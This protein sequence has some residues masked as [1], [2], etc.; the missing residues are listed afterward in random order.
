MPTPW[1]RTSAGPSPATLYAVPSNTPFIGAWLVTV[2]CFT[3]PKLLQI[4]IA[5]ANTM[6]RPT[7]NRCTQRNH[8][9]IGA[10]GID[11]RELDGEVMRAH[12]FI[13]LVHEWN[14]DRT[15][16]TTTQIRKTQ[17]ALRTHR[18]AELVAEAQRMNQRRRMFD[19]A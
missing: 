3:G 19:L 18:F 6:M 17:I 14:S 7:A 8:E 16:R 4:L 9:L 10:G 11:D 12:A 5:V 2:S 15:V 1:I 13:A